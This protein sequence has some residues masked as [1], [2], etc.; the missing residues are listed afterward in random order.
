MRKNTLG[1]DFDAIGYNLC[2]FMI[3]EVLVKA[4]LRVKNLIGSN[5]NKYQDA[6]DV[7]DFV[8]GYTTWCAKG[9]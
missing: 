9:N 8:S 1:P 5:Q 3:D 4:N 7:S 6:K 2:G